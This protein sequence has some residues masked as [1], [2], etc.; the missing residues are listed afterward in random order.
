[1]VGKA[2]V[3]E[4]RYAL[5]ALASL[6][7]A[8]MAYGADCLDVNFP[9]QLQLQ[10]GTL[11]LNGLGVRKATFL[12]VNVYV[13]ALYVPQRTTDPRAIV[14][15]S[16]PFELDLQFVRSVGANSIRDGFAEGFA[17]TAA[18]NSALQP[19]IATLLSWMDDIRTG[20][21]MSFIGSP[22]RGVQFSFAGKMKG[23]IPGEDFTRALLSIWLG[24]HPPNPELRSGLLGGPC[25]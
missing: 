21:R 19:R 10:G 3:N 8:G 4:C 25:H 6:W 17:Q 11:A 9:E 14:D 23:I 1:M 20:E 22:G 24:D 13:A 7:A 5:V 15:S 12:K 2:L 18:G 16:G